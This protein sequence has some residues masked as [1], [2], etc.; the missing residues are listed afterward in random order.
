MTTTT[1]TTRPR[2]ARI[3]LLVTGALSTLI[4]IGLVAVGGA[5]LWADGHKDADGYLS[6]GSQPFGT[7]THALVSDNLDVNLGG[8][9][10]LLD[11]GH[12]GTVRLDVTAQ[13]EKSVFVGV[14][15]TDQVKSYLH[16]VASA[17]LTDF[18]LDPFQATYSSQD[19]QVD[20]GS[21]ARAGIWAESVHGSGPQRLTW[22]VEDGDWSVVVMNADGSSDVQTKIGVGAKVPLLS[23]L[24]W[25]GTAGGTGL[26][27]VAAGLLVLGIRSPRVRSG[28]IAG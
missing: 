25:A 4:A 3:A 12:L 26:L 11:D 22:H 8:A 20:P 5:A 19:G 13:N 10:S 18:D 27:I 17:T 28:A 15:R 24:G 21:P 7:G 14:A 2:A 23:K 16:D 9:E 1:Q 6:T